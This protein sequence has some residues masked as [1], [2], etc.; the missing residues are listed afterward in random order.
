M[1]PTNRIKDVAD[2]SH[3][4]NGHAARRLPRPR[5]IRADQLVSME[6]P[7]PRWAIPG[8]VPEG[9]TILASPPK[10]GKSWMALGGFLLPIAMGGMSLGK[11][12]VEFGSVLYLALEDTER[13]LKGRLAILLGGEAAPWSL[14]MATAW[15][16]ADAGGLSDLN[17]WLA[18]H[19][20]TRLVVIDTLARF[21][22]PRRR[23]DNAYESDYQ[24]VS[25]IKAIA[26]AHHVAIVIVHHTRKAEA[27]DPFDTVSGTQGLIGA[28]DCVMV[29]ERGR[30]QCDGILHVTGRDVEE[31]EIALSFDARRGLWNMIGGAAEYRLTKERQAIV[32]ALA[33][34]DRPLSPAEIAEAIERDDPKGKATIRRTIRRMAA[35]GQVKDCGDGTYTTLVTPVTPV[36]PGHSVTCDRCDT[37]DPCDS[38]E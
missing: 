22:A 32:R 33:T 23:N 2:N 3:T 12:P 34:A 26:D 1:S 30:G 17:D 11:V 5:T 8:F 29:L 6:L 24:A 19:P 20:G 7:E 27:A 9:V 10:G 37:S 28:A 18:A 36:H 4:R 35:D 13:R 38:S 31:Q 25:E 14:E 21:R 16:R 15:H